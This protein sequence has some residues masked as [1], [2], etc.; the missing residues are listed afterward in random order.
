MTSHLPMS[1]E[2]RYHLQ[3]E[4]FTVAIIHFTRI[5][6]LVLWT[7]IQPILSG[8]SVHG[9]KCTE[10]A[11]AYFSYHDGLAVLDGIIMIGAK[12]VVI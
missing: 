6:D 4:V 8:W 10:G 3:N 11:S 5:E 12:R 9:N 7:L 1:F 2:N